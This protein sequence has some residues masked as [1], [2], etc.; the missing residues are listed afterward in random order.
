VNRVSELTGREL[1]AA[2]AEKV[3][4]CS[5]RKG[6]SGGLLCGCGH[7]CDYPHAEATRDGQLYGDLAY[8]STDI[9]AAWQVVE[10]LAQDGFWLALHSDWSG[11]MFTAVFRGGKDFAG[12]GNG[13]APEAICR[14]AL[15]EM[16]GESG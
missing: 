1:D 8:Y 11:R 12:E 7:T 15:T 2:V 5:V 6:P 14:A 10:K 3:M 16:E 9:A 4:R 13:S